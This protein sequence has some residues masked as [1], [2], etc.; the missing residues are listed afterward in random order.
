MAA[1][2][3]LAPRLPSVALLPVATPAADDVPVVDFVLSMIL[4]EDTSTQVRDGGLDGPTV[5]RYLEALQADPP[6]DLPAVDLRLPPGERKALVGDGFHRIAAYLAAGRFIIKARVRPGGR[7]EAILD[8]IAGNRKHG[9][10]MNDDDRRKAVVLL[11]TGAKFAAGEL[12]QAEIARRVGISPSVVSDMAK[13]LTLRGRIVPPAVRTTK[14]GRTINTAKIGRTRAAAPVKKK[15]ERPAVPPVEDAAET[16]TARPLTPSM[17]QMLTRLGEE[18]PRWSDL[19]QGEQNQVRALAQRGLADY[20]LGRGGTCR[21]TPPAANRAEPKE[22]YRSLLGGAEGE[23]LEGK[24]R[25]QAQNPSLARLETLQAQAKHLGESGDLAWCRR[26]AAALR[27][28]AEELQPLQGTEAEPVA[29]TPLWRALHHHSDAA[30]RWAELRKSGATDE[31]LRQAVAD[32][33]YIQ[34]SSSG[35]GL[36]YEE[37]KGGTAPRVTFGRDGKQVELSGAALLG[38]VRA[39]LL[40]PKIKEAR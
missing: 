24:P 38:A 6:E 15:A 1:A 13:E 28:V 40:I 10:A 7:E 18:E 37:H 36:V 17:K 5:K 20:D 8:G 27:Q 12:P 22:G 34:G 16:E 31:E 11:L 3:V 32:E 2:P 9:L 30:K 25:P 23:A 26:V 35:P 4:H 33:F 14:G 21:A 39:L 19:S 29:N